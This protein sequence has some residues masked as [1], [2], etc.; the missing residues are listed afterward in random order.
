MDMNIKPSTKDMS[1]EYLLKTYI[2]LLWNEQLRV[3]FQG[4]SLSIYL[5]FNYQLQSSFFFFITHW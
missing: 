3:M 4:A 2:V 5:S 1:V